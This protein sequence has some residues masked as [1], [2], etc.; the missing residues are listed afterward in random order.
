VTG[1]VAVLWKHFH[2][3]VGGGYGYYFIP[4]LNIPNTSRTFVPEVSLAV[5]L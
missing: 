3:I 2:M 4:G 1:A 5:V